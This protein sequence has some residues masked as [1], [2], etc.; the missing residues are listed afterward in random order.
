MDKS[1]K[2]AILINKLSDWIKG[3]VF[4]GKVHVCGESV[5]DILN[6]DDLLSINVCV[7]MPN[8]G[9]GFAIWLA[10]RTNNL[11]NGSNPQSMGD[12]WS[13]SIKNDKDFENI[14]IF[15]SNMPSECQEDF[16]IDSLLYN[17]TTSELTDVTGNGY[18]DF[19]NKLIR[20]N[21]DKNAAM[22]SNPSLMVRVIQEASRLGFGIEKETWLSIILNA[23]KISSMSKISFSNAFDRILITERPSIGVRRLINSGI[24]YKMI[25]ELEPLEHIYS[26]MNPKVTVME[27]SLNV[28]DSAPRRLTLRLAALFHDIGKA[29]THDKSFMYHQMV[30]ANAAKEIFE[31]YKYP[32]NIIEKVCKM[33]ELHEY[34]SA[35]TAS[36]PVGEHKVKAFLTECD[37]DMNFVEQALDLIHANNINQIYGKKVKQAQ[38][39]LSKANTIMDKIKARESE[40]NSNLPLDGNDI[41]ALLGIK[42]GPLVGNMLKRLKAE[43]MRKPNMSKDEA[44]D[45]IKDYV[46][47]L[48][49]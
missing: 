7:D 27:H 5:R 21:G 37:F 8:G 40:S 17:I 31:K 25:P 34:F 14:D 9:A 10:Y 19:N 6:N 16:S 46:A 42:K 44:I 33:I 26:N 39:I 24:L 13:V 2:N 15:C 29:E 32:T 12:E 3:S 23:D 41:M 35:Y 36:N 38:N 43:C 22:A 4:E 1:E 11:E 18:S 30:G 28:M 48:V 45:F 47:K 49:I 20:V